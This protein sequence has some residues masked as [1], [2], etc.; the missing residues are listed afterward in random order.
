MTVPLFG[1]QSQMGGAG[2]GMQN[3]YPNQQPF[4]A[5]ELSRF[6]RDWPDVVKWLDSHGRTVSNN[7]NPGALANVF[8]GND[9]AAYLNGKGWKLDRFGYVTAEVAMCLTALAIQEQ[10]PTANS[11][12]QDSINQIQ[13]NPNMSDAQKQ[14][15]IQQMK[16][17]QSQMMG[18]SVNVPE[19][20]LS[21]VKP[22]QDELKKILDINT[23]QD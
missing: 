13:S 21:L 3:P 20:E 6:M 7:E 15:A 5:Q 9:F 4:T 1:Q 14:S 18:I 8:A 11:Q 23:S 22:K 17:V 2:M 10:M 16:A 12:I 19:S